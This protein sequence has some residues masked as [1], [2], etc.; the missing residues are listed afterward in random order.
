[1]VRQAIS[2]HTLN[3]ELLTTYA[4]IPTTLIGIKTLN[5]LSH[6]RISRTAIDFETFIKLPKL[7]SLKILAFYATKAKTDKVT[8]ER[9][10]SKGYTDG[11]DR[12]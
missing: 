2:G 10:T 9:L 4:E 5:N 7:D 1:L 12:D 8:R 3:A 11:L 6:L